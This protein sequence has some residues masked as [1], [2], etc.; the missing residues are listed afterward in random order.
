M[1]DLLPHKQ[2]RRRQ[3]R[4]RWFHTCPEMILFKPGQAPEIKFSDGNQGRGTCL[5]CHDSPCMELALT[6][7]EL[8]LGGSLAGFPGDPSRDV[9]PTDAID[10]DET[11]TVPTIDTV[12]CIGCGLCAIRC[13][14]GAINLSPDGVAVVESDDPD[15]ITAIETG[16]VE[17]HVRTRRVGALG[18]LTAPFAREMPEVIAKLTDVQG[19]RLALNMLLACGVAANM[20]RKGDVNIRMDGLLLFASKQIGVVE[21]ELGAAVLE[22][23]RALLE[24]IAVLHGRFG[25]PMAQIVPVSVVGA[26][27][28]GRAEYYQVIDDIAKVL[29]IHCRTLT[30]GALCLL[31]WRFGELNG[32]NEGLFT[33][34]SGTTT[35]YSSLAQLIPDLPV[36]EPYPGA[37]SPPK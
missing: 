21:L 16:T 6:E 33:T 31:M 20:R 30:F 9:C 14:Y 36:E 25:I 11:G 19:T 1:S 27:P 34:R 13:P 23:P 18:S 3:G 12:N 10:W 2:A 32:L 7:A 35:L 15:G 8:S 17:P 29:D 28:N 26:L 22:L 24:D 4:L 5:G 37:Y